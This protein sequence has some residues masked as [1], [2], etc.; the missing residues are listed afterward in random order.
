M[1]RFEDHRMSFEPSDDDYRGFD[2]S[3]EEETARGPLILALA[4]GVLIVFAAIVWNTYRQGIREPGEVPLIRADVGPYKT[5]PPAETS[6]RAQQLGETFF[7][8]FEDEPDPLD[9]EGYKITANETL[10][11]EEPAMLQGGPAIDLLAGASDAAGDPAPQPDQLRSLADLAGEVLN[12]LPGQGGEQTASAPADASASA[13]NTAEAP[14]ASGL[15]ADGAFSVQLAAFRSEAAANAGWDASRRTYGDI[16]AGAEKRIQEAD[17]GAKGTFYRLRVGA[18]E[19]RETALA[20]CDRL[21]SRGGDCIV[22]GRT[23]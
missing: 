18:F 14:P 3:E 4:L 6:A 8:E 20:F 11:G 2:L 16:L 9:T 21:K 17:L 22:V 5:A 10:V 13:P 23:Q 12:E 19:T 7:R 1:S 15:T